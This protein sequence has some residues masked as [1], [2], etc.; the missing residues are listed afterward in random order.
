MRIKAILAATVGGLVLSGCISLGGSEAPTQLL[1]LTAADSISAGTAAQGNVGTA[2]AV[3][4][5]SVPQRLNV[6][7]VPV[8]T[9][10]ST[11]AYL[12]DAHW[13]DKPANLFRNVLVETIR[14]RGSRFVV[15]GGELQYAATTQLTGELTEMSFVADAVDPGIGSVIVR[16]DAVLAL[17]DGALRTQRFEH[18]EANVLADPV[19]VSRALNIAANVVAGEVADWVK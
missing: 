19:Q 6:A 15:E 16:Y 5:P 17:P 10:D 9:G 7:R 8:T 3:Q 18:S 1:T 14:A 11:I 12:K 2:M 4:V 13:V